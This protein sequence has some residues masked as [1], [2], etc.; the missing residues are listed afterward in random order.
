MCLCVCPTYVHTCVLVYLS[1]C[2]YEYMSHVYVYIWACVSVRVC[3][4]QVGVVQV[5]GQLLA[6]Q[7]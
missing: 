3:V 7:A 1:V 4:V 2:M 5:L 6:S